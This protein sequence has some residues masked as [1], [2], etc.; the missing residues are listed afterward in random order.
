[1]KCDVVIAKTSRVVAPASSYLE[2][3]RRRIAC[4]CLSV[5]TPARSTIC[6]FS[7]VNASREH[8]RLSGANSTQRLPV[9]V[10]FIGRSLFVRLSQR[11]MFHNGCA[12]DQHF[13]PSDSFIFK[14]FTSGCKW[15]SRLFPVEQGFLT[16]FVPSTPLRVWWNLRSPSQK[17][18]YECIK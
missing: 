3:H 12:S 16:F 7:V 10:T 14:L 4:V 6:K 8:V 2:T 18:V 11:C 5:L 1:V 17:N 15:A 9:Y 13:F